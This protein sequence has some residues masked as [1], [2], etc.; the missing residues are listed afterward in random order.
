MRNSSRSF[1]N[2]RQNHREKIGVV[3]RDVDGL[4]VWDANL[5]TMEFMS[6]DVIFLALV[7]GIPV[8]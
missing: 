4:V 7:L 6:F 3:A 2:L 1:L 8:R 5:R